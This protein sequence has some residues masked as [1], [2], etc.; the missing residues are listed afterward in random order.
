[1]QGCTV[2]TPAVWPQGLLLLPP[3]KPKIPFCR[4]HPFLRLDREEGVST[5]PPPPLSWHMVMCT[6]HCTGKI[7]V[8]NASGSKVNEKDSSSR[9]EHLG[10]FNRNNASSYR[11]SAK[12]E[13]FLKSTVTTL[14]KCNFILHEILWYLNRNRIIWLGVSISYRKAA[15]FV[16]LFQALNQRNFTVI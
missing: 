1:M 14:G 13:L 3:E 6:S 8:Q 2:Q 9:L 12:G 16:V 15:C 4:N 10:T 5:R 7:C 11:H